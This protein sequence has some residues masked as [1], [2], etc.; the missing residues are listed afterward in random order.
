MS[1]NVTKVKAANACQCH[2]EMGETDQ[3]LNLEFLNGSSYVLEEQLAVNTDTSDKFNVGISSLDDIFV[4][5]QDPEEFDLYEG[6]SESAIRI[7]AK[8][9]INFIYIYIFF[10]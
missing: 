2:V 8:P 1:F 9:G 5:I 6:Y 4:S 10:F 3:F 7:E